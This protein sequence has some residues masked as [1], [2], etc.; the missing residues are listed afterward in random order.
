MG[1]MVVLILTLLVVLLW[2]FKAR[3]HGPGDV[4]RASASSGVASLSAPARSAVV[5]FEGEIRLSPA[6]AEA[7]RSDV[8][9]ALARVLPEV[10]GCMEGVYGTVFVELVFSPSGEARS[11]AF[12]KQNQLPVDQLFSNTC[13]LAAAR[14][15]RIPA[16]TGP[17]IVAVYPFRN[18]PSS[19]LMKKTAEDL[20]KGKANIVVPDASSEVSPR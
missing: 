3:K 17:E 8:A 9:L 12:S 20:V 10:R 18:M 1:A 5:E 4:V 2:V 15:A 19:Q 7:R 11:A 16:S 13:L 6:E 14:K